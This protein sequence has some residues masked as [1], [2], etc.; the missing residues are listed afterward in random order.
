MNKISIKNISEI[1]VSVVIPCFN[2]EKF[3]GK[4]L[5]SV[6]NQTHRDLEIIIIDD[7]SS[8][9]T[10]SF[11]VD[12][13]KKDSRIV[14]LKNSLNMGVSYSRNLGIS[15]AKG[16]YLCF[17]DS[18]DVWDIN[19]I[20]K[21]LIFMV[22]NNYSLSYTLFTIFDDNSH[23]TLKKLP[24]RVNFVRL[25]YGNCIALSSTML[26]R[27]SINDLQFK[28]IGH[29]DYLFWLNY[30]SFEEYGFLLKENLLFYRIHS[31][32]I[33]YNKFKAINFTW[34]IYRNELHFDVF[35]SVY[36]FIIHVYNSFKKRFF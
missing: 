30:L 24:N 25:L 23:K 10:Y 16:D 8:D 12:F 6:L 7:Y 14:L 27:S 5:N 33:S 4:C 21:Q 2:C 26:K 28:K 35:K 31:K 32:S 15:N 13:A 29:E 18:D 36:F 1:R 22:N 20:E 34:N 19:K 3:I 11:L 9:N 17:L